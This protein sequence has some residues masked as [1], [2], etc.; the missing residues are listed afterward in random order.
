MEKH[1]ERKIVKYVK[2]TGLRTAKFIDQSR[3]GAPDRIVFY[4]KARILFLETKFGKNGLSAHQ[5]DYH[6]IL[7]SEGHTVKMAWTIEQAE[8]AINRFLFIN[9]N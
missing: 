2:E 8:A 4:P 1:L 3:K 9:E 5:T 7:K 6:Q